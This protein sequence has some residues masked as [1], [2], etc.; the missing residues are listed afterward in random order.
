MGY[1]ESLDAIRKGREERDQSK[2]ELYALQMEYVKL[3]RE[4]KKAAA[5]DVIE[6][7]QLLKQIEVLRQQLAEIDNEIAKLTAQLAKRRELEDRLKELLELLHALEAEQQSL[8]NKIAGIQNELE[9]GELTDEERERLKKQLAQ[10]QKQQSALKEKIESVHR[11]MESVRAQLANI[12]PAESLEADLRGLQAHRGRLVKQIET[13]VQQS[14][15]SRPDESERLKALKDEISRKR[16]ETKR[17]E[18]AVG[19]IIA[20]LFR[21]LTPQGLIRQWEDNTP[22]ALLPLR[23][24]TKFRQTANGQELLVRIY[25]DEIAVVTHE[26]VLTDKEIEFGTA[27]WKAL[28]AA[29]DDVQKKR[30]AWKVVTEK[31]GVNRAAWVGRQTKPLNWDTRNDLPGADDLQSPT[32]DVTKPDKWT[33]APHTKVL[34]DRFVLLGFRARE[35]ALVQIGKQVSDVVVLGPTPV[36]D[37]EHPS[38]TRDPETGRIVYDDDFKWIADF[39]LAVASGLGFRIPLQDAEARRGY[40]QLLVV[41]LKLSANKTDNQKFLE[42]L[43]ENHRYSIKGLSLIQQGTPTNNTEADDAGYS[44]N[45]SVDD[46]MAFVE[47][48]QVLFSPVADLKEATDGQRLA[49]YLG[50]R[51]DVMQTVQ[52]ANLFDHREAVAMNTALYATTLGYYMHSMLNEVLSDEDLIKLRTHT[53]KFV[54]GR[55]PLPAIRV[56]NQPYGIA[57]TSSFNEWAYPTANNNLV[58]ILRDKFYPT[59]FKVLQYLSGEW[60]KKVGELAHITKQGA[61]GET[62]M[63]V[64]GLNPTSVEYFQRIGYSYDYLKNL[65]AFGW[66]GKYFGDA[67]GMVLEGMRV[68]TILTNLGYSQKNEDGSIKSWPLLLQLIFQHYHTQLDNKNLVDGEPLSEEHLIKPYDE[69][70]NLNYIHWL[71]ANAADE[72]KLQKQDFGTAPKPHSLLYLMLLNSMMLEASHSIFLYFKANGINAAELVRSRKFMNI[73]SAPSVSPWE[74]F[75]APANKLV[76]TEAS[77]L[78]LYQY[79]HSE[80]P[81]FTIVSNLAENKWALNV[82]K[83]LPTAHLERTFAEHIDSL[84]YRLDA[85]QTSLFDVRLQQQRGITTTNE[86][87]QMGV[88]LGAYGYLENVRP[89]NKRIKKSEDVL[90]AALREKKDNLFV[91]SGNGGYVQAPTLNHATAAAI[92]RNGYLTH[93]S[94]ADKETLSVNLSSERVR[95]AKYLLDGVR[96]GQTLEALLGYQFERGLHDWSTRPSNPVILNQLKPIFRQAFPIKK[97]KVPQ[98]G[99]TTGPEEITNDYHVVNGLALAN[100]IA[101]FPYGISTFPS[102]SAD[103]IKAIEFEKAQ[104]Q[105]TLDAMRDVLTSES[106]YQLALGNFDRA[107]SVMQAISNTNITPEIEVIDSARSTNLSLTNRVVIHFNP[108]FAGNPWPAIPLTQKAKTEQGLNH[109]LGTL[110]GDPV[111]IECTVYAV[112]AAGVVLK[113]ADNSDI[114]R[115]VTLANLSIQPLDFV[116]LIRNKL[117]ASGTSE[118]E[119]RIRYFFAQAEDVSDSVIV[120]IDFTETSNKADL[121]IRSLREILPFANYLRELICGSKTLTARDYEPA[122]KAKTASAVNPNNINVVELQAR[123]AQIFSVFEALASDLTTAVADAAL[124]TEPTTTALRNGLKAFA[125]AGFVFAFPQSSLGFEDATIEVLITQGTSVLKRFDET[126]A[127]YNKNLAKVNDAA[128]KPDEKVSLLTGMAKSLLG[129]DYVLLP[130]FTFNNTLDVAKAYA[131]K[132]DLLAY[133]KTALNMKLPVAEWLHGTSLVR[134]KVHTLEMVRLLNDS[135]NDTA[136][137]ASPVQLPYREADTWLAVEYPEGTTINHDTLSFV[138]YTPQGFTAATEQCGLLVDDWT[139]AIPNK[140]EVSGIAF[141]YNQPNS[142][143]PQTVF[144]AVTPKQTGHWEWESLVNTVLD[145]IDRA[146][147]RAVEPDQLD[148]IPGLTTLLPAVLAEFSTSIFTHISLDYSLNIKKVYEEATTLYAA[149]K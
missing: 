33:E 144:L 129:A 117:E 104:I 108:A 38:V 127:E 118:L 124:K 32:F 120:K 59:L 47:K 142:S 136:L 17:R 84:S 135:F 12:P 96:N 54:T 65:D 60:K 24:E 140:E 119:S 95:R 2:D 148:T 94:S 78:P 79:I 9:N 74:V 99:K 34:P 115:T 26:K 36:D 85:W 73:S 28:F 92:L 105:N 49:D 100:V 53:T 134:K 57:V 98:E 90:P 88:Y 63:K 122:S 4:Q 55:G 125:D 91:E 48:D 69:A 112:D 101:P 126:K 8:Q 77:T 89:G 31:F 41:G 6:D 45:Q 139:E 43:L 102:L 83:D 132:D 81:P 30:D 64:L 113:R 68:R 137:E 25:P 106:A 110:L 141:N 130:R 11:E 16:I 14:N 1:T 123:V 107:A 62:L 13:L 149:Q 29:G 93:A 114:R 71:L 5:K 15:P 37:G 50:I 72:D 56:G 111:K 19:G 109:W 21:E 97:T 66:G 42:D 3:S 103:Q 61:A 7:S 121:S 131:A 44:R 145:T 46:I 23:L 143:P 58:V 146:K 80:M 87:R 10:L 86:Q 82:L 67:F 52:N 138:Q 75:K 70:A 133:A 39:D 51:Y 22:I 76:D 18:T 35:Q 116:L 27:L 20:D 128:T 147:Q 40:D